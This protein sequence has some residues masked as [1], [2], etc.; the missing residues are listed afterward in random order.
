MSF[1]NANI[2]SYHEDSDD[3]Y[4]TRVVNM[5]VILLVLERILE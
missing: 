5:K 3:G 1:Y 2:S 4:T